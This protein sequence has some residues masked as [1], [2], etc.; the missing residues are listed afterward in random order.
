MAELK[1]VVRNLQNGRSREANEIVDLTR[2]DSDR[3]DGVLR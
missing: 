1:R 3:V 2:D